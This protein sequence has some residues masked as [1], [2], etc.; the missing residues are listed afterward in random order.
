MWQTARMTVPRIPPG[1]DGASLYFYNKYDS[2]STMFRRKL[3]SAEEGPPPNVHGSSPFLV[4]I[5]IPLV[6]IEKGTMKAD[7]GGG[8]VLYDRRRSF[9]GYMYPDTDPAAY[10]CFTALVNA[11]GIMGYKVYRWAKMVADWTLNVCV[12]AEPN[13]PVQW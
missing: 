10:A 11:R 6:T 13:E 5:Q 3:P 2:P 8:I 7:I 12:D 4:K 9:I 1:K